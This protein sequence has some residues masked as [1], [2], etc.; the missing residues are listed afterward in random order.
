MESLLEL[1]HLSPTKKT[2]LRNVS[3]IIKPSRMTLQLGS[4]GSGESTLLQ[5]LSGNLDRSLKMEGN[6][7]YN[8]YR[9]DEFVPQKTS[10]YVSQYDVHIGEITARKTLDF[11]TRC[12][13]V[14]TRYGV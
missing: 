6:V 2:R 7:T 12:Q 5:A 14:G 1:L 3:G 8:G 10:A 11:A 4:P 9:L 13:G